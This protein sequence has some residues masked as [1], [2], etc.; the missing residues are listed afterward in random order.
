MTDRLEDVI[1]QVHAEMRGL[2]DEL[3]RLR[4]LD[5]AILAERDPTMWL[6]AGSIHLDPDNGDAK[7]LRRAISLAQLLGSIGKIGPQH[8]DTGEVGYD[9]DLS[10]R[11]QPFDA[12]LRSTNAP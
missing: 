9:H 2:S 5:K 7:G 3:A 6:N 12:H 4:K 10:Q 1:G 8:G 11:L